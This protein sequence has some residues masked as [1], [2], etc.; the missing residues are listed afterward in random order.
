MY[1]HTR[2]CTCTLEITCVDICRLKFQCILQFAF[3]NILCFE[4]ASVILL[5][6]LI[7]YKRIY[8]IKEHGFKEHVLLKNIFLSNNI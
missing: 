5:C 2:T 3:Y 8:V 7:S 6:C 4:I 1:I